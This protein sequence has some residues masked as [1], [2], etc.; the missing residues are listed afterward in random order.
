M[1]PSPPSPP[2]RSNFPKRRD[3]RRRDDIALQSGFSVPFLSLGRATPSP[4]LSNVFRIKDATVPFD[5]IPQEDSPQEPL[6]VSQTRPAKGACLV[7][8]LVDSSVNRKSVEGRPRR[9]K[10]DRNLAR[11]RRRQHFA[12]RTRHTRETDHADTVR[13]RALVSSSRGF[14]YSPILRVLSVFCAR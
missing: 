9:I 5:D 11:A 2:P 14:R 8:R 1:L 12:D 4:L 6:R 3:S 13:A 10:P 7:T